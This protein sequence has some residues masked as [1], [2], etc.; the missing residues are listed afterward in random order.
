MSFFRACAASAAFM[1][2][3][4][5]AILAA[6][7]G[8]SSNSGTGVSGGGA[9]N[10]SGP[11]AGFTPVCRS[12]GMPVYL[13]QAF[14]PESSPDYWAYRTETLD[15]S[16][17]VYS[18][19]GALLPDGGHA[20][21]TGAGG[22]SATN[23]Q[24]TGTPCKTATDQAACM[25]AVASHREYMLDYCNK[26]NLFD[27]SAVAPTTCTYSYVIV[28]R[29]DQVLAYT[30]GQ[31]SSNFTQLFGHVVT[32]QEAVYIDL[33][34]GPYV[35][36]D[37]NVKYPPAWRPLDGGGFEILKQQYDCYGPSGYVIDRVDTNGNAGF[38]T[39]HTEGTDGACGG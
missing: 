33:G 1:S 36:N 8:S 31:K 20:P 24:E 16:K 14:A 17:I 21:Q 11:L 29:G 26:Q 27:A 32:W 7:S 3:G 15:T 19:A 25:A 35:C 10:L 37:P 12:D 2:V 23:T 30:D 38:E 13:V 6:C 22:W 34:A 28:T 9:P 39:S 5:L 18:D 4:A